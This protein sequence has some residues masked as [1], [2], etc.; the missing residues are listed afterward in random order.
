MNL[1]GKDLSKKSFH[2]KVL[3]TSKTWYGMSRVS[4]GELMTGLGYVVTQTKQNKTK[5]NKKKKH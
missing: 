4:A 3:G 2:F 5:Q 1:L